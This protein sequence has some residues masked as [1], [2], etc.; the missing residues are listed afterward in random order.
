MND[1]IN[2]TRAEAE[3]RLRE[4]FDAWVAAVIKSESGLVTVQTF[5][6]EN[7]SKATTLTLTARGKES[8]RTNRSRPPIRDMP[9]E[10]RWT[11]EIMG[12][13]WVLDKSWYKALE[14][15]A[16]A[17]TGTYVAKAMGIQPY[18]AYK[19]L[20]SGFAAFQMALLPRRKRT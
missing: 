7:G 11:D 4:W 10:A 13:I 6:L 8:A 16:G 12:D 5:H 17:G 15:W 14:Y 20:N 19:Y 18:V 2:K 1:D 9:K 3:R